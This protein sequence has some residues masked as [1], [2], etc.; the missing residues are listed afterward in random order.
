MQILEL[1]M[2]Y[3]FAYCFI[4]LSHSL[5]IRS[6]PRW[7]RFAYFRKCLRQRFF[8][9]CRIESGRKKRRGRWGAMAM[10]AIVAEKPEPHAESALQGRPSSAIIW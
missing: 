9:I 10:F 1:L 2:C 5:R 6:L 4:Y 3:F 8:F 7:N